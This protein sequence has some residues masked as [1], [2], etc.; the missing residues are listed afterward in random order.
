[1]RPKIL[2]VDDSKTIR[3][4]VTKAFKPF[5]CDIFEA[6]NGVEGL[7]VATRERPDIIILDLTMPIMD[8][9]EMLSKLKSNPALKTIPVIMLTAEAGRE[10]VLRI[11]KMGVRDY[12]IKPFKDEVLIDRVGRVIE[13]RLRGGEVVT[14]RFDDPLNILVVDDKPA[15]VE[16]IRAG[17]A[18]TPWVITSRSGVASAMEFCAGTVPDVVIASLSLPDGG[19]FSLFQTMRQSPRMKNLPVFAMSVKTAADEQ[20]RAQSNGFTA[21]ITKPI[22]ADDIKLKVARAL[23]LDTSYKYFENRDNVL[24]LKIPAAFTPM[25]ANEISAHLRTK[26]SDAVDCG[27][28]KMIVDMSQVAKADVNIIK[29]GLNATQLCAELSLKQRMIGSDAVC[30]ECKNYEETKDWQFE[31]NFEEALAALNGSPLVP[32]MV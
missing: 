15:I 4:I 19:A 1:M 5:D 7:A 28:D 25:V 6:A 17:L 11:A 10:N 2:T 8:G 22:D 21:I 29:L 24:L 23:N 27:Y 26:I 14:K 30:L 20:A 3:M 16:Q 32:A 18:D 13:L 31:E 12:L 9:A